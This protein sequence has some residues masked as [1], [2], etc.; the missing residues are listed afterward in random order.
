MIGFR[1]NYPGINSGIPLRVTTWDA[2]G[3]YMY[4]PA[5]FIYHDLRELNWFNEIDNKYNLSGG[6][7]YQAQKAGNGNYFFKYLGG[8]ALMEMPAFFTAHALTFITGHPPDGFSMPYQYSIVILVLAMNILALFFLRKVLLKYFNDSVTALALLLLLLASNYLQYVSI[9]S[10]MSHAFIFPLYVGLIHSTL[11]WHE[12][13]SRFWASATGMIIGL[14]AISRP[15]EIIMV[16]IPLLWGM[17][18]REAAKSKWIM[19]GKHKSHIVYAMIFGFIAVLPQLIYWKYTTGSFIFDVGSKWDFLSP[20]FRVLFGFEKG[21]FIY[22]PV[23][24]LF[25]YGLFFIRKFPFRKAVITFCL[26][27]IYIIISWHDWRYGASYSCRALVQSYPVLALALGAFIQH[28][29]N[30]RM[31]YLIGGI[32][33]YLIIVNLFQIDQYSKGIIHYDDMNRKYYGRIYLD[34][35]PAPLDMSLLDTDEILDDP[36]DY[37]RKNLFFSDSSVYFEEQPYHIKHIFQGPV[38]EIKSNSPGENWIG[39]SASILTIYGIS[40]AHL[41]TDVISGDSIKQLKLRLFSPISKQGSVTKYAGY[42][43]IPDEFESF[44]IRVY[45]KGCRDIAGRVEKLNLDYYWRDRK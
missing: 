27:N 32:G 7:F 37:E 34:P 45:I 12:R 10:A 24:I 19:V 5:T 36:G 31:R 21:W 26:L 38:K 44:S 41:Y 25:I 33:F 3:Y 4:L 8:V 9:E 17:E 29:W 39:I 6:Y 16:F 15:T 13:P 35:N 30:R 20:H 28:T 43:Y 11:K 1:L 2:L 42:V 40:C 23:A 18:N 14:A 22:T